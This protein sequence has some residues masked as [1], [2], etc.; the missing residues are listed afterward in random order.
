M[1]LLS[2]GDETRRPYRSGGSDREVSASARSW[3]LKVSIPGHA[4]IN[5]PLLTGRLAEEKS[6]QR[7][8]LENRP[9]KKRETLE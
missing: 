3:A 8:L 2:P 5:N 6:Q 9:K 1:E 4:V 7:G